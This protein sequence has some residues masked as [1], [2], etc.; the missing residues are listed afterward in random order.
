MKATGGRFS[1]P[2][3]LSLSLSK[4]VEATAGAGGFDKLGL[5]AISVQTERD[6]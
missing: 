3:A 4:R 2:L 6:Q 1:D 5:S